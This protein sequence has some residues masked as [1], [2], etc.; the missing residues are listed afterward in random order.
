MP[1]PARPICAARPTRK[2]QA[3]VGMTFLEVVIA[4]AILGLTATMIF[5]GLGWV[6]DRQTRDRQGMASAELANRLL[7]QYLDDRNSLPQRSL[8]LAYGTERFRWTMDVAPITI[9]PAVTA[10]GD[11]TA[12]TNNLRTERLEHVTITVWL[13]E[14]SG[15]AMNPT[16]DIPSATLSRIVDPLA[17]NNPDS[18]SN[19]LSSDAGIRQLIEQTGAGGGG[20][21]GGAGGGGGGG[22][23]DGMGGGRGGGRGRGEGGGQGGPRGGPGGGQGGGPGGGPRPPGGG[24]GGG[25]RGGG[26]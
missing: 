24:P 23:G 2:A 22:R 1:T 11:N 12:Q 16:P 9:T 5:S 21:F 20:G 7:L 10:T 14:E 18:A 15:G 8:P 3:R 25:G 6:T 4:V 13:S 26:S 19:L 17:L